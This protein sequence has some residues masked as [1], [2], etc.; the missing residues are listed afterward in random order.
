MNSDGPLKHT[1]S[2]KAVEE[3]KGKIMESNNLVPDLSHRIFIFCL[4]I[5]TR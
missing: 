4:I 1:G 5:I 2:W 3:E